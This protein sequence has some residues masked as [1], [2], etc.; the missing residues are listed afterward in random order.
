MKR[1][2]FLKSVAHAGAAGLILPAIS[3]FEIITPDSKLSSEATGSSVWSIHD[4]VPEKEQNPQ[5]GKRTHPLDGVSRQNIK[6][7]D[8]KV[9]LFSVPIPPEKWWYGCGVEALTE[10]H[11]DQGIVGIGGPSNYGGVEDIKKYT[12]QIIRPLLIGRN[13]F[14]LEVFNDGDPKSNIPVSSSRNFSETCAWAGVNVAC[15]DIIGK[16]LGKPVWS[17]LATDNKPKTHIEHYASAGT[18]YDWHKRP[19]DLYDEALRY[20]EE[21]F[22]SFKF[23]LGENF[24]QVMTIKTYIPF[25]R[26]LRETV[27]PEFRLMQES[28]MRLTLDQCLEIVPI[29]DELNFVW[30]EEPI[31]RSGST[32]ALRNSPAGVKDAIEGHLKI[33][34]ATK[35]LLISGGET[36]KNKE[37]FREWIDRDAYDIVQPDCDTTGITEGWNIARM[38]NLKNKPC[39]PHNWHG[40]LTWMSNIQLVAGIPNQLILESNR[41]YN[42]FREGLFTEPII[43][44]NSFA[45][46]PS[47]PGLGVEII[48]DADRKFPYDPKND[49]RNMKR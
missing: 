17:F 19:E 4:R 31:N 1:R 9:R 39:V 5:S 13:P 29:L 35:K 3:N 47:K 8:V 48:P 24:E 32:P 40:G 27:G 33:R 20:K 6:I 46:A 23:R 7:T 38:A 43:V 45:D 22:K 26:K 42:P 41:N 12:D 11:T 49:W 28:N 37:E 30:F 18:L 16:A 36:M 10:I 44:K 34:Q 15:W 14:D 2:K 21:G 25:L